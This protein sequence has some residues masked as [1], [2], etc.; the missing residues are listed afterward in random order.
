MPEMPK[1]KTVSAAVLIVLA[2]IAFISLGLPDGLL[3]VAWPSMRID[4]S[5][6]LD[7]LGLMLT[8]SMTGYLV[9]SFLSGRV[10]TRWGV[11]RVLAASCGATGAALLG[12]TLVPYWWM[13]IFLSVV[14]GLGAGAI[15]AGI[16][17]YVASNFSEKLM[18]W[19]HA[20][21]GIGITMGP[22]IMTAG[23]NYFTS[24]KLGYVFVG[25]L[26]LFLCAV[27]AFTAP[28]WENGAEKNIEQS[29]QHVSDGAMSNATI[30]DTL[31]SLNVWLSILLFFF[32]AGIEA[33]IGSWTYTLLTGSRGVSSELAGLLVGSY[34][35]SFTIGRILAGFFTKHV[36]MNNL[37]YY[38][39]FAAF[40]GGLLLW[41]NPIGGSD[42]LG[43]AVIG[44]SIAPIFPGMVSLTESR[45]G[46]R[47][48]VNTIGM[49][50]GAAGL[51][52]AAI[53]GITGVLAQRTSL[54]VIP[55]LIL[56]WIIILLAIYWA[57]GL[58]RPGGK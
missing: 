1:N 3:G 5:R 4:F 33:S 32:Y 48:A 52:L 39:L 14:A 46:K 56:L 12:Y 38:S 26:Q 35:A 16:N 28:L 21:Y 9:S 15:D 20:S 49:Q 37:I 8:A 22:V 42:L 44:F 7:S 47:F 54:E 43:V 19:L 2:Y 18:Q 51:G 40:G 34:W 45:V 58:T 31:G 53:P 11:G 30:I 23:I 36:T 13:V 50:I 24:W 29:A 10:I 41:L 6:S 55:V 57:A 17:T 27:F 25:A